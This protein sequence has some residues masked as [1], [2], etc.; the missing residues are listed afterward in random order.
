MQKTIT[1]L[2][3]AAVGLWLTVTVASCG[4]TLSP[5]VRTGVAIVVDCAAESIRPVAIGCIPAVQTGLQAD[6]WTGGVQRAADTCTEGAAA[7][8]AE[9]A[10]ACALRHIMENAF[11]AAQS[12][13]DGEAIQTAQ[14]AQSFIETKGYQYQ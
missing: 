14:R 11:G 12:G 6:D 13:A 8:I 3:S 1:V 4:T 10:L 2:C 5:I 9:G 7:D